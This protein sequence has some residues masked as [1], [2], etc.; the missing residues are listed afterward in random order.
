MTAQWR[1]PR[2]NERQ[3]EVDDRSRPSDVA[4]VGAVDDSE[5]GTAA[6]RPIPFGPVRPLWPAAEEWFGVDWQTEPSADQAGSRPSR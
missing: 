2:G 3:A 4:L 6:S 5:P 1:R